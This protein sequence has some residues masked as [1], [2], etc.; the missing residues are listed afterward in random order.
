MTHA[1]IWKILSLCAR[2]VTD[3]LELDEEDIHDEYSSLVLD[4]EWRR[5]SEGENFTHEIE[6]N[7]IMWDHMIMLILY[8]TREVLSSFIPTPIY[9]LQVSFFFR[10]RDFIYNYYIQIDYT[11]DSGST[12]HKSPRHNH[13]RTEEWAKWQRT[14]TRAGMRDGGLETQMRLESFVRSF[15]FSSTYYY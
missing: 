15:S 9:H 13:Q 1:S 12:P 11:Y 5:D 2:L 10:F 6:I 8:S 7:M 3:A 4:G 14:D